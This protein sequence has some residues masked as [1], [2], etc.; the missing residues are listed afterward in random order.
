MVDWPGLLKWSL[1][2]TD[3]SP[4]KDLKPLDEATRKWLEEAL[5]SNC[6]DPVNRMKVIITELPSSENPEGLLEDLA[7]LVE[8]LDAGI[9]FCQLK[10]MPI[11][12]N[13]I[14]GHKDKKIRILASQI[15]QSIVQNSKESQE[16]ALEF[17]G[18]KLIERVLN[19]EEIKNK[20]AAFS[21]LSAMVRGELLSVKREFLA[22]NGIEFIL[23]VIKDYKESDKILQ[24]SMFLL[25]DLV[26]YDEKM[27]QIKL[28]LN[29]NPDYQKYKGLVKTKIEEL[30]YFVDL[31]KE[32]VSQSAKEFIEMRNAVAFLIKELLK[33]RIDRF[34]ENKEN[35]LLILET[36]VKEISAKNLKNEGWYDNE[37]IVFKELIELFKKI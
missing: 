23:K 21:A 16:Y 4:N 2:Q 12:L 7:E 19:E 29:E 13:I 3:P 28:N 34:K 17:G 33:N 26:Y 18:L 10:G 11:L 30:G 6:M 20:E 22:A 35:W 27:S 36:H 14:F 31:F 37:I 32:I 24:K 25:K 5:Q 8:N 1:S 9:L 15:L